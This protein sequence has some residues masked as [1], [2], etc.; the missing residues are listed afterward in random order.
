MLLHLINLTKIWLDWEKQDKEN[1]Q[2]TLSQKVSE[3]CEPD[4]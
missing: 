4:I 2:D 3:I 1:T